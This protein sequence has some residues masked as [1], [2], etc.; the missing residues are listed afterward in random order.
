[1]NQQ[2]PPVAVVERLLP[3]PPDAVYDEWLNAEGMTEWMCPRPA[4]P[5][6]IVLDPCVGGQIRIDID[7]EGFGVTIVGEYLELDRP[8]KLSFTW[9]A[10]AWDPADPPSVVTVLLA[11]QGDDQTLMTIHHAQLPPTQFDP[12]QRGWA[13]VIDQLI[14]WLEREPRRR[15][16]STSLDS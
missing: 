2:S 14:S 13:V 9:H 10:T 11:P 5:T 8:H 4:Q 3:A 6:K 15:P 12:H 1:M 7:D 16:S